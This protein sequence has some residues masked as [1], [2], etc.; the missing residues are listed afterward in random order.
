MTSKDRMINFFNREKSDR[1]PCVEWATWWH[2]TLNRWYDTEGLDRSLTGKKL[3]EHFGHD[4]TS[5]T[6]VWNGLGE[7]CPRVKASGY[8]NDEAD[9]DKLRPIL[10]DNFDYD[11][12]KRHFAQV[13]EEYE[14]AGDISWYTFDGYF[15]F[16]RNLFGIE[17]HFYS[18]YDYPE[19]YHRICEDRTEH[20]LKMIDIIHENS[21]PQF[22]TLGE[23]M[24]YNHGPML[25][26]EIFDEF[27]APHY[28]RIIPEI[29]K[30]GTKVIIDSDGDITEM[31]PWF[32]ETGCDGILPLER[33]AGVD[34]N[35]LAV[36]YPDFFFIGGYDKMVMKFGEEEMKKEFERLKPAMVNGNY[37]PS[38]DHQTPPDVSLSQYYDYCKLLKQF[39]I[40]A[41]K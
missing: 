15:W 24:S 12:Y 10:Y 39:C 9:Y 31:I 40:D 28:K 1:L 34:I 22:M 13:H 16:P 3:M 30:H 41:M 4:Y 8:I 20:I 26:R 23:D 14:M 2:L 36:E 17:D 5:Q 6:W 7:H 18:F 33:Q 25:S 37:M 38:V 11:R 19:L 21:A 29:H 27:L 32:I 35:K